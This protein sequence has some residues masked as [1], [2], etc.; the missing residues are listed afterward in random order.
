MMNQLVLVGRLTEDLKFGHVA[1]KEV[2]KFSLSIPRSYKNSDGEYETD[3][4]PVL[5]RDTLSKNAAKYCK[6]GDVIGIKGV[7][8]SRTVNG[9]VNLYI[10]ADKI[11]FLSAG[12][13]A[14]ED[15]DDE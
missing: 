7:I 12:A 14:E 2:A 5:V 10:F 15:E 9:K 11:T 6:K 13:K 3:T 8:E 4:I 1:G